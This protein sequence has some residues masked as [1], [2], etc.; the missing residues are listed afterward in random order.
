MLI[1]MKIRALVFEKIHVQKSESLQELFVQKVY[2]HQNN[3]FAHQDIVTTLL[4][5]SVYP[6]DFFKTRLRLAN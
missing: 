4:V 1:F 2:Q 6:G 5:E 3:F